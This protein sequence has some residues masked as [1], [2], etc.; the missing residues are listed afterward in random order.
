M[1]VQVVGLT[2]VAAISAGHFHSLA[3]KSDGTVWA[4][5]WN[6]MGQLGDGTTTD[7]PA[8]V[9]VQG[10][11]DVVAV[12]AGTYHSLAV[13]S[14]GTAWA[15]GWNA[16]GQLGDGTT[17][18]RH[19]PVQVS[20]LAAVTA[21][22]PGD[23]HSLALRS[24]GT[25]WAWGKNDYGQL[26]I[27]STQNAHAPV[28]VPG[29]ADMAAIAPGYWHALA[30]KTDG[31]VWTWGRNRYGAIGDGT[32]DDR[33]SPVQVPGL[34]DI[35]SI[36]GG[37]YISLARKHGG[38]VWTW[39]FNN[40]GQIGDGTTD[41][42]LSPVLVHN[43]TACTAVFA[44][45]DHAIA[46]ALA[47]P[48]SVAASDGDHIDCV[49]VSW[50]AVPSATAYEVWRSTTSLPAD[51]ECV[52]ADVADTTCD[53]TTAVA[54][55]PYTYWV[56][57][58]NDDGTSGVNASDTGYR[59][60]PPEMVVVPADTVDFGDVALDNLAGIDAFVVRNA[61]GGT[62]TGTVS[63]PPPFVPVSSV[64]FS[65]GHD[66]EK[67]FRV[68]FRPTTAGHAEQTATFA[69]N[70]GDATRT[71]CGT[72]VAPQLEVVPNTDL[73]FGIVPLGQ[74]KRLADAFTVSNVGLGTLDA[75]VSVAAPFAVAEGDGPAGPSVAL[76]L[77]AD[78]QQTISVEFTPAAGGAALQPVGFTSGYG[79]E[80]RTAKG[81]GL[82]VGIAVTSIPE[83]V[84]PAATITA[85]WI[86]AGGTPSVHN[87]LHW[88]RTD[89]ELWH[90][91]THTRGEPYTSSFSAP[92]EPC[93]LEV[94]VHSIVD[95]EHWSSSVHQVAVCGHVQITVTDCPAQVTLGDK[96]TVAWDITG[97][98]PS[99]H[100][101]LHWRRTD[102]AGWH[103]TWYTSTPPYTSGLVAPDEEC[104][105]EVV[106]HAIV[107]GE[108]CYSDA[109]Q[110]AVVQPMASPTVAVTECPTEVAPRAD[111]TLR[112]D[113]VGG[114]PGPHNHVHW[115]KQ[116]DA[117]W[118]ASQ[119]DTAPP[120]ASTFKA[121]AE[122]CTLEAVVHA[123]VGGEHCFSEVRQITVAEPPPS[124]PTITVTT[125]PDT[126]AAG[127]AVTLGWTVAGGTAGPH[128]H[129]HW[130]RLGDPEWQ[131]SPYTS[132]EPYT[133]S[134]LAPSLDCTLEVVVHAVVDGQHVYSEVREVVVGCGVHIAVT[135]CPTEV[136][137]NQTINVA[138]NVLGGTAGP[139]NHVHWRVVGEDDWHASAY[140]STPPYTS[141]FRAPASGCT[142]EL[143][144]H[145]IVGT[146]HC[147]SETR[148]V[149]VKTP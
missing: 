16:Y 118:R 85:V 34:A 25:V 87:H 10:L 88:R 139:H 49:R 45:Y 47:A 109:Q 145:T 36:A 89:E 130:R 137:P 114:T 54:W 124:T 63:V 62:L 44:G 27:G 144:V 129:L 108:A 65:L 4:W 58:R 133:S 37:G 134:F 110:I 119:Y 104:T 70:A 91:T 121:P 15:W 125:C 105:L 72:G 86:I 92:A 148:T 33:L 102:E 24:D 100:N 95:G 69:S 38:T 112:W 56:K 35:V 11:S 82:A 84:D 53:D 99:G 19:T 143:K 17:T 64:D 7:R 26:G 116:G 21:I 57:A 9:L 75:E 115:R 12:A 93:T 77:G 120:Y 138:W 122:G 141:S 107:G 79:T 43:L 98:T 60:S 142:V 106:V 3:V 123:V 23:R 18:A 132:S 103:G 30:L 52:A 94:K 6:D 39:G 46:L 83:E 111:V 8:P 31:T 131:G 126:A 128:N 42:R 67:T 97:G 50:S 117:G 66:E 74:T 101:H 78:E 76:S 127:E 71:V 40:H 1:P 147:Y 96:L 5:G 29:L 61:G 68:S 146:D 48:T 2:D 135:D 73:D 140:T 55:T 14:D 136:A 113:V 51:A 149:S 41:D 90:G 80:T 20:G 59:S 13:K 28:Q 32:T 22:G 81:E